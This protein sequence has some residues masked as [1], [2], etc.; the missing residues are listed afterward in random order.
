MEHQ[1]CDPNGPEWRKRKSAMKAPQ[2]T[3][4][5]GAT[6]LIAQL[7]SPGNAAPAYKLEPGCAHVLIDRSHQWMFAYDDLGEKILPPH[8]FQA[9]LCDASL[10]AVA[11]LKDF[12]VV[13]VEQTGTKVEFSAEEVE[14]LSRYVTEGGG[15]LL[16]GRPDLPIAVV[17]EAFGLQM[18]AQT[19]TPPL[20]V[21]N[22][23]SKD[24]GADPVARPAAVNYIVRPSNQVQPVLVDSK[25]LP[26][27]VMRAYGKGRILLFADDGNYWDFCAQRDPKGNVPHG[28]ITAALFKC[29]APQVKP[30]KPAPTP[31][32]RIP[33]ELEMKAGNLRLLHSGPLAT[34]T[35][36]YSKFI[37]RIAEMVAQANGDIPPVEQFTVHMLAGG[38]G[39]WSG[40]RE[41]G[42]GCDGTLDF[43]VKVIAHELTHSWF[44]PM[45]GMFGEGWP[46]LV[47]M[48]V[49]RELGFA[50]S[51]EDER[52]QWHEGFV[53]VDPTTRQLDLVKA[54]PDRSLGAACE[55]K[56]MW[57]IE[58]LE[59][60][61][62]KDFMRRFNE[63]RNALKPGESLSVQDVLYLFCLASDTD[64]SLWY[65]ELGI[66]YQPPA[67]IAPDE[68]RRKLDAYRERV[69]QYKVDQQ[70]LQ[71]YQRHREQ[72]ADDGWQHEWKI[73]DNLVT[74]Q[75]TWIEDSGAPPQ[76]WAALP[77]LPE[78]E[79]RK[80]L[81]V[82]HAAA[83]DKPCRL[84]RTLDVP[85]EGKTSVCIGGAR[86]LGGGRSVLRLTANGEVLWS[87]ILERDGWFHAPVDLSKFAG[88][89]V[90]L[91]LESDTQ[92]E[93]GSREVVL[94]YLIVTTGEQR[95]ER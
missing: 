40:G 59:T 21:A 76:K 51:A 47:G 43:N 93:W 7:C 37:P 25:G 10:D 15:L 16:V 74:T 72:F 95:E 65:R 63:A 68:L 42:I 49:A 81:L 22:W 28:S 83:P 8:G 34:Q 71:N 35:Q 52:R 11:K 14:M 67:Q 6:L 12:D 58:Q 73:G 5:L 53:K 60:R 79:A 23:L 61:F 57:M 54:E 27:A 50:K 90:E 69:R 85:R 13:L 45:V 46:S 75:D 36:A 94:D 41:I 1:G 44:G 20:L 78:S 24:F 77:L 26:V 91:K 38:G 80:G 33:G 64:L 31:A 56:A 19:G 30:T 66:S 87:R 9:V 62:G 39:G 88:Q 86:R 70:Q 89:R 84:E 18:L 92:G 29:L 4:T 55:G 3:V 48:R 82:I 2:P 17:A 32:I